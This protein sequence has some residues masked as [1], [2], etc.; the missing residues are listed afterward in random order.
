MK[1][2][3]L[4]LASLLLRLPLLHAQQPD[5]LSLK[6]NAVFANIDKSQVPTRL[7]M[8][9]GLPLFRLSSFN[10]AL[11]DSTRTNSTIFR[12]LY[13][14]A[15]TA[16]ITGT[17]PLKSL[18]DYNAQ[19]E[20]VEANDATVIP[21]MV[22]RIDFATLRPDAVSQNLLSVQNNQLYDVPGRSQSPYQA[23]TFFAAAPS[24]EQATS[25]AVRVVIPQSLYVEYSAG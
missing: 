1:K 15:Y 2:L 9:Y 24:R 8:E 17:N 25:N 18:P 12:A 21:I 22:Q 5:S 20:A 14:S 16:C 4:L 19:V 23:R 13:A 11:A 3:Y 6:L 10:G 7:L